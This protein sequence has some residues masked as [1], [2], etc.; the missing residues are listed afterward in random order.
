MSLINSL[1][2]AETISKDFTRIA[3]ML[4]ECMG[5]NRVLKYD[6]LVKLANHE[7]LPTM[8]GHNGL[9]LYTDPVTLKIYHKDRKQGQY[10]YILYEVKET[11]CVD[12]E[13]VGVRGFTNRKNQTVIYKPLRQITYRHWMKFRHY[14]KGAW[15]E[16]KPIS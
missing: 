12:I 3:A 8:P 7:L 11:F 13:T 15:G 16:L 1:R 2:T 9:D 5:A 6:E 4:D 14:L 10:W